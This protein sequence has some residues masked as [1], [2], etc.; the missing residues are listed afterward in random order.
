MKIVLL[1]ATAIALAVAAYA[2]VAI[3]G[4]AS[5][6]AANL[7]TFSQ[8]SNTNEVT[9]TTNLA[10]T[11]T[12]LTVNDAL[13]A[14]G[15]LITGPPPPTAF[16]DLNATSIDA[17]TTILS[18]VIQH[19]SGSFCISTA[20]GCGGTDVL[21]GTFSDAAFGALDGPGLVVNVNDP[22]DT[23]ALSSSL[24]PASDLLAPSS[25]GLTFTNVSPVL[26][27]AGTTLA[28]FSATFAGDASATPIPEPSTLAVMGLGLLGLVASRRPR[29]GP[30]TVC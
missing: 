18:A 4:L 2:A 23:L 12:T 17:T 9:A 26:A 22:P 25:F 20:T 1:A 30:H 6:N 3:A 21:S 15:Q 28:P 24:I 27:I 8:T 16:F 13:V 10:D 19:Y 11:Q 7:I 29:R 5:A 14:I